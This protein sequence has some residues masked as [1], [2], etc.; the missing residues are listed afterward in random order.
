M[1]QTATE[2]PILRPGA[3]YRV[4]K[5][6]ARLTW[7]VPIGPSCWRGAQLTLNVGDI[8]TYNRCAY[9]GGSDDVDYNYFTKDQQCGKFWPNNW[10][11]CDTS[12]LELVPTIEAA[13]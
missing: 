4:V 6:G 11:R 2:T 12:F 10:G 3:Q 13:Q 8:I 7:E 9:G 1:T 5:T